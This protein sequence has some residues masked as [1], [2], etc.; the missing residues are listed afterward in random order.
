MIM[1][2]RNYSYAPEYLL[3]SYRA[4]AHFG[5]EAFG[6]LLLPHAWVKDDWMYGID[7]NHLKSNYVMD[8]SFIR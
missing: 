5:G 2:V 8:C 3:C 7:S 6:L 1:N 4:A